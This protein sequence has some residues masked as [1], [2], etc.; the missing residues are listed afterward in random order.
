MKI[1]I[2]TN[3]LIPLEPVHSADIEPQRSAALDIISLCLK[4]NIEIFL[5]PEGRKD[6]E[7]DKNQVRKQIRTDAYK[8]YKEKY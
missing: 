6:I 7:N 3:V 5:D 8:K 1:L 2:D 4:N